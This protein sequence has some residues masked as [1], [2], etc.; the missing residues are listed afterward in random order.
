MAALA[1]GRPDLL[2]EAPGPAE[3]RSQRRHD[4]PLGRQMAQLCRDAGA[5]PAAIPERIA[6]E[7]RRAAQGDGTA[8]GEL[9]RT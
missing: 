9:D 5:G 2:A 6:G 1:A 7:R 8:A 4:E 3:S